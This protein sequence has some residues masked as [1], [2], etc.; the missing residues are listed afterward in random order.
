[1]GLGMCQGNFWISSN[2][3]IYLSYWCHRYYTLPCSGNTRMTRRL[4]LF[5]S[6]QFVWALKALIRPCTAIRSHLIVSPTVK[7]YAL[8][9][10]LCLLNDAYVSPFAAWNGSRL[11]HRKEGICEW[12]EALP[13]QCF[14]FGPERIV[15]GGYKQDQASKIGTLNAEQCKT[16][17]CAD[18]ECDSWQEM[19]GRGCYFGKLHSWLPFAFVR[20]I[21]SPLSQRYAKEAD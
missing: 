16:A 17:C 1:M 4:A 5:R 9:G 20:L 2:S 21:S 14:G 19:T 12:G 15:G 3:I 10:F 18:S 11:L 6:R 13:N 8:V 7:Q